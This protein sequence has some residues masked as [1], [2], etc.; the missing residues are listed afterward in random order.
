MT[1]LPAGLSINREQVTFLTKIGEG[2]FGEVYEASIVRLQSH[3]N[4]AVTAASPQTWSALTVAVK[5]LHK[6]ALRSEQQLF[7]KEAVRL[8]HLNHPH[9]VQL[10]AV[11]ENSQPY[12]IVME[13]MGR[14]DLKSLLIAQREHPEQPPQFD[15]CQLLEMCVQ[16]ARAVA[17]LASK[18]YVHRD[19]A[20]RNVFLNHANVL[21]LG[22]FG[23]SEVAL[24]WVSDCIHSCNFDSQYGVSV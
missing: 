5:T 16:L 19:I 20:A 17:Y 15:Q 1:D 4:H 12:F 3:A 21:K 6:R 18:H 10:L 22:D 23:E 13:L 8:S 11:C 9:I 2:A 24:I 14:G 7:L